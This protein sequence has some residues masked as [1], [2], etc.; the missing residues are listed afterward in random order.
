MAG[1]HEPAWQFERARASE[2]DRSCRAPALQATLDGSHRD[3]ASTRAMV[4][5]SC[6]AST[7]TRAIFDGPGRAGVPPFAMLDGARS[8]E[9]A[10]FA[11]LDG[12]RSAEI[13]PFAM[14][15][16][17][18]SAEIAPFAMLDGVRS[19]EIAPFA[20][21]DGVRS[22]EIAGS[23][24]VRW[25]AERRNR[26]LLPCSMARGAPKSLVLAILHVTRCS[27]GAPLAMGDGLRLVQAPG[28]ASEFRLPPGSN[29]LTVHALRPTVQ[30]NGGATWGM[31]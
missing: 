12:V 2:H 15:D 28:R 20:M 29:S 25:R 18:R 30:L 13:A 8:A 9:I 10:P 4:D 26:R 16:G 24:H 1:S 23:C 27:S 5:G 14:L 21:L 7:P 17:V 22:A 19:A 3:F 31:I 6:R 11:V